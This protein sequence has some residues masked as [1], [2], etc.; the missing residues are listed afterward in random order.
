VQVTS[1]VTR[2]D[3][4]IREAIEERPGLPVRIRFQ[5]SLLRQPEGATRA[6][7]QP[8]KDVH[9]IIEAETLDEVKLLRESLAAFF[10]HASQ[11]GIGAVYER[12][13]PGVPVGTP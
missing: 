3:Q 4:P 2:A 10:W 12:L 5:P 8:W 7:Y 1:T 11:G 9:W 13:V 6:S